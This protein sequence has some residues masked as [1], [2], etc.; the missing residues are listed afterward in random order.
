MNHYGKKLSLITDQCLIVILGLIMD[1]KCLHNLNLQVQL[2][3]QM[4][5]DLAIDPD[6]LRFKTALSLILKLGR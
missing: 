2:D 6:L 1:D 3:S 4:V 5:E